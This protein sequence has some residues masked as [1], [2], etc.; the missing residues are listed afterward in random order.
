MIGKVCKICQW[1][2]VMS[3]HQASWIV[4]KRY[5]PQQSILNP[6][7]AGNR[8]ATAVWPTVKR[9]DTCGE[10]LFGYDK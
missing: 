2:E 4:C 10:W 8:R 5:A 6:V 3:G 1:S 9:D 7:G